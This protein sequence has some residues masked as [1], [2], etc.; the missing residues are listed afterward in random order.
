[1]TNLEKLK[2]GTDEEIKI[3]CKSLAYR[4]LHYTIQ[5]LQVEE[6]LEEECRTNCYGDVIL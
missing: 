5:D 2:T 4:S 1:M 3:L 6:W